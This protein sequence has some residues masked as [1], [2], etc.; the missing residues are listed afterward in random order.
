MSN[1]KTVDLSPC[2]SHSLCGI[3]S[4][5]RKISTL[6]LGWHLREGFAQTLHLSYPQC[7]P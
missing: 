4:N 7:G 2:Q 3:L 6:L 1:K 5:G